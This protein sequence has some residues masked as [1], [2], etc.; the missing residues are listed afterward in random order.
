MHGSVTASGDFHPALKLTSQ[1]IAQSDVSV[2][3]HKLHH[4]NIIS[5]VGTEVFHALAR[6]LPTTDSVFVVSVFLHVG[7]A[8]YMM[9]LSCEVMG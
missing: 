4:G 7:I 5:R 9:G 2:F 8:V 3:M 6:E 1:R